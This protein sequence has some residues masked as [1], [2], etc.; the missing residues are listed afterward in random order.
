MITVL[1]RK[2]LECKLFRNGTLTVIIKVRLGKLTLEFRTFKLFPLCFV[3]EYQKYCLI[4]NVDLKSTFI[5]WCIFSLFFFF[6]QTCRMEQN[7]YEVY[8]FEK[9]KLKNLVR[10][11]TSA[12][13]QQSKYSGFSCFYSYSIFPKFYGD[14]RGTKSSANGNSTRGKKRL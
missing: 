13:R 14:F 9:R 11:Q 6:S 5:Y 12:G 8:C 3:A 2:L 4:A 7:T 10:T 1:F